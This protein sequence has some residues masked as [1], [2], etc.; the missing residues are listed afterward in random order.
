MSYVGKLKHEKFELGI[1]IKFL[2]IIS[3]IYPKLP[4]KSIP[5]KKIIS[6]S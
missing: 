5:E 6:Y 4:L 3:K 1:K 2:F